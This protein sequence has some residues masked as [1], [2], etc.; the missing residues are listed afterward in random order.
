MAVGTGN[1]W[2]FPRVMSQN[3]GG[4]FLIP[5]VIFL[6]LWSIPLLTI[7]FSLGQKLR[8]GVLGCFHKASNGAL[9]WLGGFVVICTLGIMFYYSVVTAWCLYYL[10]Q[11]VTGGVLATDPKQFWE[12]FS[13]NSLWPLGLH[14]LVM[15]GIAGILTFGVRR[16]I[17]R[18]SVILIPSLFVI[19]C[20]LAVYA[21]QLTGAP[22]GRDF[23][24]TVDF[25]RLGDYKVWLEALTQSAWSTG[26]GWGLA[27]TYA[28]FSRDSDHPVR[29]PIITGISNNCV[30]LLAVLVIL[31]TLFSFF[32]LAQV[33]ELTG[34][35]NTG[36]TFIALPGLFQQMEHGQLI[37]ILFFLALFFAAFTS[38]L[39]MFALG[40]SFLEDLKVAR[41][42][43][44]VLLAVVGILLWLRAVEP[45]RDLRQPGRADRPVAVPQGL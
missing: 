43:A 24:F 11:S 12:A 16:G 2:R 34:E 29:T 41:S 38:L 15:I 14:V 5:W 33:L 13:Q 18:V 28:G 42:K 23:I 44:I 30:E 37:A 39:A 40:V 31:P 36:L 25:S 4:A 27:L 45:C 3:G 7:E 32:P 22:A 35:G 26:A 21:Q 17:E 20:G 10:G 8:R 6:A 1:I 19:L 9:S